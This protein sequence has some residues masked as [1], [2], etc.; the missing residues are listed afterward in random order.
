MKVKD[1]IKYLNMIENENDEIFMMYWEKDVFIDSL[2][3]TDKEWKE[4]V[5][6]LDEY[7]FDGLS[8]DLVEAIQDELESV[9]SK[10]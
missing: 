6:E 8:F 10:E 4:V 2:E 9:R 3:M 7:S 5:S 1:A